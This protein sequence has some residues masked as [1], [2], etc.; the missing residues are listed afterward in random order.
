M[1]FYSRFLILFLMF[2]L[3]NLILK[4]NFNVLKKETRDY[5][6]MN[7]YKEKLNRG[8]LL[9]NDKVILHTSPHPDDVTLGYL[10]YINWLL[11]NSNN[12]HYFLTMTSGANAVRNN[13]LRNVLNSI[14][15]NIFE[16]TNNNP[17]ELFI[18]NNILNLGLRPKDKLSILDQIQILRKDLDQD[19]LSLELKI[20]KGAIR[21]F[22]EELVWT[23]FGIKK[24][25]IIHFRA[26]FYFYP[27]NG[28]DK[29]IEN[30]YQIL[31]KL[32]PDI[33]TLAV[34][35][36]GIGP[37]THYK[38]FLIIKAAV[39]LFYQKTKK[40]INIIGYRNV[41]HQFEPDE[42]D[43]IFPV[44]NKDFEVLNKTF[45]KCYKTQVDAM[46]PNSNYQGNFAQIA[47]QIMQDNFLKINEFLN[48]DNNVQGICFLKNMNINKFLNLDLQ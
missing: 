13:D 11:N 43:V 46:F 32:N 34:D 19:G 5:S 29:D 3:N 30:M 8:R 21:E 17:L 26:D 6:L 23:S 1:F 35:P 7:I 45:L 41:W 47:S 44:N 24:E 22:E 36:K 4:S 18:L 31:L 27:E 2:F 15:K 48:F 42:V 14:E 28:F 33:I 20:L 40:E 9:F 12:K 39:K 37:F 10:P 38:T 25:N 16:E